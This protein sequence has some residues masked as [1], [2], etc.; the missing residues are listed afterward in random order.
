MK[1]KNSFLPPIVTVFL[2]CAFIIIITIR[3]INGGKRESAQADDNTLVLTVSYDSYGEY[4][5]IFKHIVVSTN[6]DFTKPL[7]MNR[8]VPEDGKY[9]YEFKMTEPIDTIYIEPPILYTPT[10]IS[11]ISTKLVE[12]ASAKYSDGTEWFS[13]ASVKTSELS[14]GR[15]RVSV[16]ITPNSSDILPRS[17]KLAIG[18]KELGGINSMN[19]N[20]SDEFDV[21]VFTFYVSA[22]SIEE[23][24]SL[25]NDSL[26]VVK[27]ALVKV[28]VKGLTYSSNIKTLSV[29]EK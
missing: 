2:L 21:G 22:D 5:E 17:P 3:P 10:E 8:C 13:I 4:F 20:E 6:S 19:F 27:D 29:I 9:V 7:R 18:E 23:A 15:Y 16:Y 1:S 14:D 12:G 25:I 26:L 24:S 11:P 28:H